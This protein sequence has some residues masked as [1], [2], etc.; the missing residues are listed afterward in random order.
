MRVKVGRGIDMRGQAESAV[1]NERPERVRQAMQREGFDAL[2][3]R[4]PENVLLLS[5]HLPLCGWSFLVF[6]IDGDPICIVPG[7]DEREAR[8][9]LWNADCVPFLFGVLEAGDPYEEIAK[10]LRSASAGRRWKK[11]GYEAGFE[12]VAPPSNVAEPIVPA[13]PTRK[14]LAEVFGE[15]Q[16]ADAG[17]LLNSQRACKTARELNKLRTVNEI[18]TFGLKTFFE[19]VD[20]GVSGIEL[21]AE[22]EHAVMTRGSGYKGA[23]RVRAFAQVSTGAGETSAG[24]RPF[25][26]S[27]TRKMVS[28]DLALLELAVVADG[29][30]SDRTRVRAAG[31]PTAQQ[32]EVH[33]AVTRALQ[34]AID[35]VQAGVTAGEIDE[36]ARE[37]IRQA[38]YEKAF[39]HI[40]G[41][42]LGFRYHEPI[43][44][45]CP[46]SDAVLETGMVHSLEPGVY[47]PE[48]GGVRVEDDIAVTETGAEVLG[49]FDSALF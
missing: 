36:A 15:K 29:F 34:A 4:L 20:V 9:E 26:I 28:G 23:S 16:L 17:G 45:I 22:V 25:V 12:A 39:F 10:A 1:D 42:G 46:G 32:E 19:K 24:S 48:M 7:C 41:H 27:T 33:E 37:V 44:M 2:V 21:A 31:R 18:S 38:G 40:S 3:C 35:K 49:P 14:I 43:P 13:E 6:P 5:G 11:V 47:L 30:W 8:E